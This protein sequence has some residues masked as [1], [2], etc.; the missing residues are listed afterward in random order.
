MQ[1]NE[2]PKA[3]ILMG[4]PL[5]GKTTWIENNTPK[6]EAVVSADRIKEAHPDYNPNRAELLHQYSVSMAEKEVEEHAKNQ[7]NFTLDSGSINNSYTRRL[8]GL[9]KANGYHVRLVHIETPLLLCL[10]RN[11]N[12]TRKVPAEEII[13]KSF[14]ERAQFSKLKPL[15]DEVVVVQHFTNRHIFMDMDGVLAAQSTIPIINGEIDFV[16]SELFLHQ[17][18]VL[19]VI[20]KCLNLANAGYTLYILS[21]APTSIS[22][23][24]KHQWLDLHAP[25]I[26][27]E[28]RFFVNQGRH[29][30][31]MLE[32]LRKKLKLDKRDVT[33]VDD[34][35]D[36]LYQVLERH[37]NPMHVSQF[38]SYNF[39]NVTQ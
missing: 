27:K 32:G 20:N 22:L 11:Q 12:R 13:A 17:D 37:M 35:H 36:T 33:L 2:L 5:A 24:E 3:T 31:E 21:G 26:P 19:P 10:E 29:K 6:T 1:K 4:L 18:P 8:I 9:L 15:V 25:F 16:N 38:L 30:A 28:R 39:D 23:D 14:K 34:V 7:V